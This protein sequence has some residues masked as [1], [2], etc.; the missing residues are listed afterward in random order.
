VL[1]GLKIQEA[2]L[3][4]DGGRY[5][6]YP[7]CLIDEQAVDS[8]SSLEMLLPSESYL[9]VPII[10]NAMGGSDWAEQ[11]VP[12]LPS[13]AELQQDGAPNDNWSLDD[14]AAAVKEVIWGD[15]A[16][17]HLKAGDISRR[18]GG[19]VYF[20]QAFQE[21]LSTCLQSHQAY[22][23]A[24]AWMQARFCARCALTRSEVLYSMHFWVLICPQCLAIALDCS[25][26][27]SNMPGLQL[28]HEA[29]T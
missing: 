8:S 16:S 20:G 9:W 15:S 5:N 18:E 2:C 28:A 11:F 29:C 12:A 25:P 4:I 3:I 19:F 1:T 21:Q 7:T 27:Q 23:G 10:L 26:C 17:V 14:L 24:Q 13:Q 6:S 22:K